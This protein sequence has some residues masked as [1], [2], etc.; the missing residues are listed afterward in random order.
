[1]W[2]RDFIDGIRWIWIQLRGL[3]RGFF[4]NCGIG[5]LRVLISLGFVWVSKH[6]VDIA[7][8]KSDGDMLCWV[9][10]MVAVI[11][12]QLLIQLV[13]SR[14]RER[15]RLD[16]SNKLRQRFFRLVMNSRWNG[17]DS[18]HTGDTVNRLEEDIR[19]VCATINE[20]IPQLLVM[21]FQLLCASVFLFTMQKN[22][23]WVLL[24]IMP[25]ALVVSRIYYKTLRDLNGKIR[26]KDSE[27]Q[28]HLQENLLKRVLILSMIKLDDCVEALSRMQAELR[29]I[30][31]KK[32]RCSTRGRFFVS[33][34]FMTGYC[35]TFCWGA[36]GILSGSVTYG[37]MTAFLQLVSQVQNPIVNMSRQLPQLVQTLTSID[38]LKELFNLP[39]E[40]NEAQYFMQGKI[41]VRVENLTFVYPGNQNPTIQ[42][43]SYDFRPGVSTA[44]MGETGAGKSTLMKVL[45]NILQHQEGRVVLYNDHE[46]LEMN[47][48]LRCNF[49]YVPQGNSL[50]SGTVRDN[51]RLGKADAT[52]S[53]MVE[54]LEIACADFV[55]R[56]P[57]GLDTKCSEQGSGLSEGQAQRI[58]IARALL[59]PGKVM[60]MDEACSALDDE[61]ERRVLQNLSAHCED[62]TIIW[63]T[64]HVAVREWLNGVLDVS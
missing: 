47:P 55:M 61:T 42:N 32:V 7:T 22:L 16:V 19:T 2:G 46:E 39:Q 11:M 27:I 37:M 38:R 30:S 58:A 36:F 4:I 50:I 25:I 43:M 26:A 31:V 13:M 56:R 49:M 62:R 24:I 45:L 5:F 63:I 44:I 20:N 17:K 64:H 59:Q 41:G 21:V 57:E 33:L 60:L 48:A 1:M 34:G 53:E 40:D 8:H 15:N 28:S 52:D 3:R 54:S 35:V 6:I 29:D 12:L 23:L 14:Y 9:I 10:V 51:L 18:L